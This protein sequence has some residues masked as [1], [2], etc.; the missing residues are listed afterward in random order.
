[1][2]GIS[3][4][5]ELR[6][7]IS[8]IDITASGSVTVFYSGDAPDGQNFGDLARD[9]ATDQSDLRIIDHTQIADFLDVD[10]NTELKAALERIVGGNPLEAGTPSHQFMN[11]IEDA[12]GKRIANGIWD[13]VSERFAQETV[14]E[15]RV[16]TSP[17][18]E[19][20]VFALSE[21][22]ALLDNP[23]V[24]TIDGLP[25]EQLIFL[26]DSQ[27]I[28]MVKHAVAANAFAQIDLSGLLTGG[29]NEYRQLDIGDLANLLKD[30]ATRTALYEKLTALDP[31]STVNLETG[32][33][34]L[35]QAGELSH[36][37]GI[38]RALNRV[39]YV[40]GVLSFMLVSAQASAAPTRAETEAIM[41]QWAVDAAGGEV[42]AI[43]AGAA[44]GIAVAAFGA[45]VT[46]VAAPVAVAL[47]LG[48]SLLGGFFGAE[49]AN[50]F[51]GMLNDGDE[52]QRRQILDRLTELYF[53]E[54]TD[55]SPETLPGTESNF[56]RVDPALSAA[57]MYQAA[58]SSLAWRYALVKLNPFVV[59]DA[60]YSVLHNS[61]GE[62]DLF[63]DVT[64]EG[65]T[66][67][68]LMAR[69]QALH[70]YAGLFAA[71]V[72]IEPGQPYPGGYD[73]HFGDAGLQVEANAEG[74]VVD[75]HYTSDFKAQRLFGGVG[76]DLLT[77][78]TGTD[79]LFGS[80]GNDRLDGGMG[81]DYLEGG[82]G[83]D[84][85]IAGGGDEI[86][87]R[88]G[89]G[90]VL[91]DDALL[92]GGTDT[93]SG[94]VYESAYQAFRY[95]LT[96]TNLTVRRSVDGAELKIAHFINGHLGISLGQEEPSSP[97]G[98]TTIGTT[99][100]D[101]IY[102]QTDPGVTDFERVNG[103]NLPDHILGQDGRD[104]IYAWDNGPQVLEN[105]VVVNSAPDTDIVEGG[106]GRD[107][108][109]GGA[110]DDR[111]FATEEA[112]AAAVKAGQG[113][114]AFGGLAN[115]E[116]DFV[117]GQ[118]GDDELYGSGRVDGLF[119]GDGDDLI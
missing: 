112:D 91:F 115:D 2:D 84:T 110:G 89:D 95:T 29:F 107:F 53:G 41:K 65:L 73:I 40:G 28:E 64:R 42:G 62:L 43:I 105:G 19:F 25:R 90:R 76:N 8:Q 24:T 79:M 17:K 16:L 97:G 34:A 108:I 99:E 103:F 20:G 77:G 13:D 32:L 57:A 52:S 85:Y 9:L 111:L 118:S 72:E 94:G 22:P 18:K 113:S 117:S 116:G 59:P 15:V 83:H 48:A 55:V 66:D 30:D 3:S 35:R 68:Y 106:P 26:R 114:L 33:S 50:E 93:G 37:N 54:S 58:R 74:A 23:G 87:D 60:N 5:E 98:L 88:D 21:L 44:A 51:H 10:T 92:V 14:G 27:G 75:L 70:T 47:T 12:N 45:A 119:G 46:P 11:G 86:F 4:V 109:H 101:I 1:L 102:G 63:D 7:L 38:S 80:A 100:S 6:D 36:L 96:D 49:W 67:E 82:Q 56:M 31:Q 69:A 39:G 78:S 61:N 71:G 104:W 81:P